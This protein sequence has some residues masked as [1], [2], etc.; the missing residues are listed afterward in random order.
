MNKVFVV[1]VVAAACVFAVNAGAKEGKSGF[2]LTG[3]YFHERRSLNNF[4][5]DRVITFEQIAE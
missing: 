2:Y 4:H 3:A 5:R 1:S